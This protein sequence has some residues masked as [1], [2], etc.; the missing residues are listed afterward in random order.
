MRPHK[1]G[2]PHF[3]QAEA[4]ELMALPQSLHLTSAMRSLVVLPNV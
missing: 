2:A 1:V 3:G 4:L